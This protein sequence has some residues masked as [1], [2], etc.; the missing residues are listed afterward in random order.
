MGSVYRARDTTLGRVVALKILQWSGVGEEIRPAGGPRSARH[1]R[2]K[3][4]GNLHPVRH[5]LG[6]DNADPGDGVFST[7]KRWSSGW[8]A[9]H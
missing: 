7:A 3:S 6:P 4:S 9:A 8:R 1:L 5:V 2:V